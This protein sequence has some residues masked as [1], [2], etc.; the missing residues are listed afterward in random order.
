MPM[1]G[2]SS[3]FQRTVKCSGSI[4]SLR[5]NNGAGCD[6]SPPQNPNIG[7]E[8]LGADC[9]FPLPQNPR[10]LKKKYSDDCSQLFRIQKIL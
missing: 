2:C 9:Y 10:P 7:N 8:R 1:L 3:D 5:K 6:L 4:K